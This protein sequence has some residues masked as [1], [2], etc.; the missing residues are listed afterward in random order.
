MPEIGCSERSPAPAT[1]MKPLNRGQ[2]IPV[3]H[4]R[5][6]DATLEDAFA[7]CKL[8]AESILV[9]F[10]VSIFW[11]ILSIGARN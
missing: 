10:L 3:S 5:R 7:V 4:E 6:R 2:V 1:Q 9:P 11:R 8:L